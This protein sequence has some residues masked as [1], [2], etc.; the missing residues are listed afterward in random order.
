MNAALLAEVALEVANC[1][2]DIDNDYPR[3]EWRWVTIM[4][5]HDI[6]KDEKIT[7]ETE[8]IDE[9]VQNYFSHKGLQGVNQF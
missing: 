3:A 8:D 2:P 9:L 7:E 6:I 1:H 4:M 5:A